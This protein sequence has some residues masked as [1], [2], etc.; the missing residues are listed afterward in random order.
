MENTRI[1]QGI[2]D[3]HMLE[4]DIL[5][6]EGYSGKSPGSLGEIGKDN[7]RDPWGNPYVYLNMAT[8]KSSPIFIDA[9]SMLA[10]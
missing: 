4:H 8:A 10:L 6:Q 5:I 1:A 9:S 3:L 7:L 2:S